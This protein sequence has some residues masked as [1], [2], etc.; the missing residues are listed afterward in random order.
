MRR[1][2]WK[3]VDAKIKVCDGCRRHRRAAVFKEGDSLTAEQLE[4]DLELIRFCTHPEARKE[5]VKMTEA[6]GGKTWYGRRIRNN[7]RVPYNIVPEW[8]PVESGEEDR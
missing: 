1:E 2:G 4:R 3:I 8:C 6:I 5:G 7:L